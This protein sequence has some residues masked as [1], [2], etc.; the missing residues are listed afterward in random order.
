MTDNSTSSGKALLK[1]PNDFK[2]SH[3]EP[4]IHIQAPRLEDLQPSYAKVLHPDQLDPNVP[5]WYGNMIDKLGSV[6]GTC[7]AFPCCIICPNPYKPVQQGTVGLV[8]RFGRFV[9]AVDPGLAKVNPLS[10]SLVTVDVKIQIVGMCG[11]QV[12]LQPQILNKA[13]ASL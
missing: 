1:E 5:S 8:T 7:G 2:P 3:D 9:R 11:Y 13:N 10:E 4:I 6:I 12:F